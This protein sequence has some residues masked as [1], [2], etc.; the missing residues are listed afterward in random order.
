MDIELRKAL[1]GLTV[2]VAVAGQALGI[3]ECG[4][5]GRKTG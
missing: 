3:A 2:P 5:C 1:T 4:L